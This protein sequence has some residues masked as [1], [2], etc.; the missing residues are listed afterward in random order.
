MYP[1]NVLH[2]VTECGNRNH[3]AVFPLW[4]PVWF[5]DLF[6]RSRRLVLL[7]GAKGLAD[8]VRQAADD[9]AERINGN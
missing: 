7:F 9:A 4:L 3:S 5:I 8:S 2:G 6:R 1:T